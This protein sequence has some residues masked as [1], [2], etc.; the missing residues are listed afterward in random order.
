[1]KNV[2]GVRITK[3]GRH[4]VVCRPSMNHDRQAV[5]RSEFQLCRERRALFLMRR[6]VVMVIQ[7]RL[8]YGY[9]MGIVEGCLD[10]GSDFRIPCR[11]FMRMHPGSCG[12]IET[13][14]ERD[15]LLGCRLGI[16]DDDNVADAGATSTFD[17]LGSIVVE[18]FGA[19]VAVCID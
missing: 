13:Q 18:L 16:C 6:I 1:M 15:S 8:A 12:E 9:N 3:H 17:H 14:G 4:V 11:G 7:S 19:E 10:L 5:L 2:R